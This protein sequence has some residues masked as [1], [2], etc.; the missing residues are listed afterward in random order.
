MHCMHTKRLLFFLSLFFIA[1]S[2]NAQK[3]DS[4]LAVYHDNY[5][6]EKLHLHFDKSVYNSGETIW[7]KAYIMAGDEMSDYSRN[8]YVDWYDDLGQLVKHTIQPVYQSSARGQFDVPAGYSGDMLH[9]K[10]YTRW[11][12]NFDT[13]FVFTKDIQVVHAGKTARSKPKPSLA[14]SIQFFPEGGDLIAG[15]TSNVAFK[16]VNQAGDPVSVR[17]A[18]VNNANEL[19]DS[20]ATTHDGMGIFSIEP[21]ANEKYSCNWIDQYGINHSNTLP[22]IKSSGVAIEIQS[23][24]NKA[25]FLLKRTNDAAAALKSLH[26]VASINQQMVYNAAI[27][28]VARKS[29]GSEINTENF[30]TGVMQVTVFDASWIPVAER[31]VFV[32]NGQYKFSP[33]INLVTKRTG[34]RAR[35]E[36]EVYVPDTVLANLSIAV[37]DAGLVND[38]TSNIF[39]QL[40]LQGDIKG[41]INN[42]AYYF[43]ANDDAVQKKLDLVMLTHGW[44]RYK[45]DE[46]VKNKIPDLRFPMDSDYVQIKGRVMTNGQSSIKSGTSMS[47]VMQGQGNNKQYFVLPLGSDGSFS[48]RGIIFFDSARLFY[49]FGDK[50]LNEIA[51]AKFNP[52]LPLVPY[53]SNIRIPQFTGPDSSQLQYSNDFYTNAAR[54]K[55]SFDSVVILKEVTVTSKAKS[56]ID[57]LDEKYTTGLFSSN[58]G[59][60]FDVMHDARAKSQLDIFHYLQNVVPG[61]TMS[62]PVLGANGTEDANSSNAP[63]LNYRDGTPDL[64]LN[65]MP[66]D[67][68]RLMQLQMT[69]VAYVKVFKPPFMGSTGSGPSGAIVVYTRKPEDLNFDQVKGLNN[70]LFVGYTKY[71]EFYQLDYASEQPKNPDTRTTLYWNPYLLTDKKNKTV[72]F[73]FYNNDMTQRFRVVL[74]GVNAEGKLA[75]I[76]K[77]IE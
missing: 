24:K 69:D 5:Q 40:L 30:Q 68:N 20:F 43:S 18:I 47:L 7:Y 13:A 9:I 52:G 38:S 27:N 22:A 56:P 6:P 48:Q 26:V 77:I 54:V 35:N 1:I 67:A 58:N 44:R 14:T 41:K 4:M 76:E 2:S 64:F 10:A 21:V 57:V 11:M 71:K 51:T 12:L 50:R 31:V 32:N 16:A 28:L 46:I 34:K 53:A 3:I 25:I 17:G 60:Q 55:K 65:E 73:Q 23:Q 49:Q 62:L 42:A 59:Y 29:A 66:V 75:R 37:T 19:V 63:G 72:K 33:E 61:L 36:V 39:S 74:E 70:A 45:W 8:F 15:V